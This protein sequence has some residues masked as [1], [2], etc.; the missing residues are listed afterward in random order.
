LDKLPALP[1][2]SEEITF[3]IDTYNDKYL[4]KN[5]IITGNDGHLKSYDFNRNKLYRIY[6][7]KNNDNIIDIKKQHVSALIIEDKKMIK[8]ISSSFDG[9]VNIWDFHSASLLQ[10]I[11]LNYGKLYGICLWD[12]NNLLIVCADNSIKLLDTVLI[13]VIIS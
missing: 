12:E 3:F 13:F 4:L 7:D 8:L 11:D 6:K 1:Q 2:S 10:N 5:Y 9:F